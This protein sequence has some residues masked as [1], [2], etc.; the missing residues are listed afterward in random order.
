MQATAEIQALPTVVLEPQS[1]LINDKTENGWE[2]IEN[3]DTQGVP[4]LEPAEFL[5]EGET[6]IK[7]DVMFGR[8]VELGNRAGQQHAE[9]LL[10][11]QEIIPEE[12]RKFYLVFP[13]T[14]WCNSLGFLLVPYLRW[15][16][17]RWYLDWDWLGRAWDSRARLV[18]C[19]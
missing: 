11:R 8:A 18:R 7:G 4:E 5:H 15:Y 6:H 16:G 2:L 10:S 13:G 19:K 3:I 17:A 1:G 14:K 12:W 9:R